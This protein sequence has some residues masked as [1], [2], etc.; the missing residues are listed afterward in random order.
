M[1]GADEVVRQLGAVVPERGGEGGGGGG[2]AAQVDDELG[3]DAVRDAEVGLQLRADLGDERELR[4]P[5]HP[6]AHRTCAGRRRHSRVRGTGLGAVLVLH[7][8]CTG[9]A[10]GRNGE[11]KAARGCGLRVSLFVVRGLK[12]LFVR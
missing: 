6:L 4:E 11:R 3:Q 12:V 10:V 9:S 8:H 2:G 1:E 7:L 5:P